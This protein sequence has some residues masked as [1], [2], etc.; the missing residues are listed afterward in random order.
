M[1]Q[2]RYGA[3]LLIASFTGYLALLALGTPMSS[4]RHLATAANTNPGEMSSRVSLL[5]GVNGTLALGEILVGSALFLLFDRLYD[6]GSLEAEALPAFLILVFQIGLSFVV[7][8]PA[9]VLQAEG[10]FVEAH[11]ITTAVVVC[12]GIATVLSLYWTRS[13]MALALVQLACTV[14]EGVLG[15]ALVRRLTPGCSLPFTAAALGRCPSRCRV[16]LVCSGTEPRCTVIIPNRCVIVGGFLG[17][18]GYPTTA[19]RTV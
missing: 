13:L 10:H 12:R 6:L 11:S 16:Q 9:A 18:D 5:L 14:C 4:V 17:L 7:I 2:E 8:V 1:G 3:W 19:C 15:W